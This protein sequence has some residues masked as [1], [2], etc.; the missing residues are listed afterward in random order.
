MA[1]RIVDGAQAWQTL[2][3]DSSG[4]WANA[5]PRFATDPFAVQHT[6]RFD[7]SETAR[8]FC[9][10]SC[11][12]RNIEE[13]LIYRR[14]EVLS[15]RVVS[16][17]DEWAARANGFL[18][19]F[20]THSMLQELRWLDQP[21]GDLQSILLQTAHGWRD[22]Q[23]APELGETSL[24]R[25]MERRRYL[26][27][28]YFPRLGQADVV[29]MTLGLNE[30]WRDTALD[31]P[32]NAPPPLWNVR[33]EPDRYHLEI[34]DVQS[35]LAALDEIRSRL[36]ALNPDIKIVVTVSPVPMRAT[37]SGQDVAIANTLSKS[38]L[39]AAA[40]AFAHAHPDVDYFPSYEIVS[41]SRRDYAFGADYM[42]VTNQIVSHVMSRFMDLY[43]PSA[44]PAPEGFVELN[45]LDAN[46]DVEDRVRSGELSS[47]F[48]HWLREGQ[49]EGRALRLDAIS[50]RARR[51]GA[52]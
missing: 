29:L 16:P 51:A 6:P 21:V 14:A 24:E 52:E 36:K 34:T 23:L 22:L 8:Y 25:A 42:H 33:R 5:A 47:G 2:A 15:K 50:D 40:D 39:R 31:L 44:P 45:Y 35:N 13:H 27:Q 12:A 32:L 19:K 11:F 17:R 20:T 4:Q 9:M 43:C 28:D 30:L 10:G 18:N 7:L 3:R 38:T 46:P 41:L 37:F 1:T 48:E 49:A 26:A